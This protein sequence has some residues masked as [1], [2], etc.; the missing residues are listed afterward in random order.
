M[1]EAALI[2]KL[3]LVVQA[4]VGLYV[5]YLLVK[6]INKMLSERRGQEEMTVSKREP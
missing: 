5:V 4:L 2:V 3:V 1:N 6:A